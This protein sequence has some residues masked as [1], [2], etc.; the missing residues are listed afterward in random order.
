MRVAV[1]T[2]YTYRKQGDSYYSERAFSLFV[3]EVA[4]RVAGITLLGRLAPE[5]ERARYGIGSDV[6]FVPLPYYESLARPA[7]ALPA[8]LGSLQVFW[9]T[10]E[11]VE[12]AWLLGPHPLATLFVLM[13][14]L[15]GRR[16]VLGI[17]Q[18]TPRYVR[19]RRPGRKGLLLAAHAMDMTWR[20]MARRIPAVV[21]G[22]DL[23]AKYADSPELLEIAV[24]LVR[25]EDIIDGEQ[26]EG[27]D[28][29]DAIQVICVGRLDEEKNPLLLPEVLANLREDGRDWRFFIAGEGELREALLERLEERGLSDAA[30]LSGY[31]PYDGGLVDAYRA[32]KVFL[33][34]SWT[35][36]LPQV[37]VEAFAAGLPVVA[38]DVGGIR[39]AF[40]DA[41]RLIP[42]GDPEAAAAAVREV[43]E[44]RTLRE[45]LIEHGLSHV[46]ERTLEAEAERVARFLD[47]PA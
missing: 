44:N 33:H 6:N 19:F 29:E 10:L 25:E 20:L 13:A 3:A 32:S 40:P 46:R 1:Y 31:L 36:G 15:R 41:L 21:V 22:P 8:M 23:A 17:R 42:P 14:K 28:Y 9:R 47:P 38:T 34:V 30:H 2:D 45:R 37:L 12:C 18:D 4:S 11:R 7:A 43:V 27:R 5:G 24:S 16:V 35:E 26:I 39:G